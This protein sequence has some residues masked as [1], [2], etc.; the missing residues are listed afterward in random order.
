[1]CVDYRMLNKITVKNRYPV[2]RIDDLLDRLHG[3]K[4]FTKLDL[5]SG[6]HQIRIKESAPKTAFRTRNGHYEYLV[7]PFGLMMSSLQ[8]TKATYSGLQ[9]HRIMKYTATGH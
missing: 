4:Y 7:M 3:A 5:A 1:M 8:V 2:P 9:E 6:Y